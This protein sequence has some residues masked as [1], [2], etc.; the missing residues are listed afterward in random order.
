L[1]I[2]RQLTGPLR[3][4]ELARDLPRLTEIDEGLSAVMRA[5][6]EEHPYP[7]W[8][9]TW[10]RAARPLPVVV[11]ELFP[12][13]GSFEA[14]DGPTHILVAGCGTG[15]HA[16]NV[17]T[18]YSGAE[19]LAIDLSRNSLAYAA[20]QAEAR[21]L[22]NLRFGQADL[23]GLGELA[24]GYHLIEAA[25]VL[26]HL[27]DPLAGARVLRGLLA[28]G[29]FLRL[30]L[31]SRA[32]RRHIAA[33]RGVIE[34]A[35]FAAD[36]PGIRAARQAILALP[37]DSPARGASEEL[38]FYSLAGCRDLLFN[39]HEVAFDIPEIAALIAAL[40]VDFLGF[41]F[42]DRAPQRAYAARFPEDPA[43]AELANW[44]RI[45]EAAP[46]TFRF[47]YQF[48]CRAR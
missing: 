35:G 38:D 28:P 41:E 2:A 20:A 11:R 13:A 39:P 33:A 10:E 15:R 22:R 47:M 24:G 9:A 3:E 34:A 32:A 40:D 37:A 31:Y 23:M 21:G 16:V 46:D 19:V 14:A 8:L 7:R 29:G 25:G 18:R 6:Y 27:A 5:H 12:H 44:Q 48:W 42:F 36:A 30:G 43:M 45:E 17:A 1:L 26:H 4:R